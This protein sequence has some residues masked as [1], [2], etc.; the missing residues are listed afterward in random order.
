[1]AESMNDTANCFKT[2]QFRAVTFAHAA[3]FVRSCNSNS[4]TTVELSELPNSFALN[5]HCR[6]N[7]L[8]DKQFRKTTNILFGLYLRFASFLLG[9]DSEHEIWTHYTEIQWLFRSKLKK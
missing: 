1:M 3:A 5:Y 7:V 9:T 4:V 8:R 2:I 6:I